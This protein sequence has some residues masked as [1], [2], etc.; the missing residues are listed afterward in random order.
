MGGTVEPGDVISEEEQQGILSIV[1]LNRLEEAWEIKKY[2]SLGPVG[3]KLRWRSK[4]H[5]MG[6]FGGGWNWK[7]GAQVGSTTVIVFLLVLSLSFTWLPKASERTR[8]RY[9][10][11]QDGEA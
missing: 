4:D 2:G 9:G 1:A 7:L 5:L 6:R 11:D 3:V 10:Y 8:E